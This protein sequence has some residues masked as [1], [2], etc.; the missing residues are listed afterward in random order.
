M[1]RPEAAAVFS[2]LGDPVRLELLGRLGRGEALPLGALV[3]GTGISRQGATKHLA[4]LEGA[5]LVQSATIGRERR[6][7]LRPEGLAEAQ[8]ALARIAAG[9]DAA[10]GRLRDHVEGGAGRGS[11]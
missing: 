1:S 3:A 5:G 6:V 11:G 7:R 8:D 10:L 2:A 4:V 9:W